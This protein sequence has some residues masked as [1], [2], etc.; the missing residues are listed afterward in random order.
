MLNFIA[1]ELENIGVPYEFMRWTTPVQYPYFVGEY[2]ETTISTEDGASEFTVILTGFTRGK[3]L[4]LEQIKE[5]IKR[6]FPVAGGL[7][8][9]ID[10]GAVVVSYENG[11]PVPT[12][13]AELKRIQ[14]N[15]NVKE[16]RN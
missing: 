10:G 2:Q 14:I 15:L 8:G 11:F 9:Q 6:H 7:R 5:K 13:E 12:G 16:W 1:T 3:W 4:E